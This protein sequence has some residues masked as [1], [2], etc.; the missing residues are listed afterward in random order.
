MKRFFALFLCA[1]TLLQVCACAPAEP[2]TSSSQPEPPDQSSVQEPVDIPF[3]LPFYP[4]QSLHPVLTA[5]RTNLVLSPL[6]YEPLFLVDD[7]FQAVP[8]LCKSH[9]VSPDKLVWTFVL[10]SGSNGSISFSARAT[11]ISRSR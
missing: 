10:H 4:E 6:L 7:S 11:S 3:A 5:N 2:G 1:C 8:V 9:T